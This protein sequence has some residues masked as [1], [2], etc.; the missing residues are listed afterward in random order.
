MWEYGQMEDRKQVPDTVWIGVA[1]LVL[2]GLLTVYGSGEIV[3]LTGVVLA[4]L[5]VV[6]LVTGLIDYGR[7]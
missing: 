3:M 7:G 2:G 5:G 1:G 6:R 4:L